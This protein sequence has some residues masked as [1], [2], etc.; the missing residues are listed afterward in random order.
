MQ[1]PEGELSI[2][3]AVALI[4]EEQVTTARAADFVKR[5]FNLSAEGREYGERDPTL[6]EALTTAMRLR[7]SRGESD[8]KDS[9]KR[10]KA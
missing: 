8:R 4:T 6:H 3:R 5:L 1:N 9:P 7:P 10:G 2:T